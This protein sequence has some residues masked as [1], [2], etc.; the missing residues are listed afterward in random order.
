VK[1]ELLVPSVVLEFAVVGFAVVLQQTPLLV[2]VAFP[3][4]VI[5]PPLIAVVVVIDVILFVEIVAKLPVEVELSSLEQ[6]IK[7]KKAINI[8]SKCFFI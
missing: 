3:S 1:D 4:L 7:Q 6:E 5:I 2:I 8:K